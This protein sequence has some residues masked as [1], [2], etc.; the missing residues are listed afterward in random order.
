MK[1]LQR[2]VCL[3]L[4]LAMAAGLLILPASAEEET[5][6]P[7]IEYLTDA[8]FLNRDNVYPAMSTPSMGKST[9][10]LAYRN[11]GNGREAVLVDAHR[12]HPVRASSF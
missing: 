7:K 1:L 9:Y 4:L 5:E 8:V 6:Y 11:V 3:L 10:F 12:K 2:S